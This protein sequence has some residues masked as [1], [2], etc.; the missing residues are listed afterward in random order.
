VKPK[1]FSHANQQL[2]FPHIMDNPEH[3]HHYW[4]SRHMVSPL[5]GDFFETVTR[6]LTGAKIIAN[7]NGETARFGAADLI[8]DKVIY[9]SKA[10]T[11]LRSDFTFGSKQLKDYHMF[12][13]NGYEMKYY[14]WEYLKPKDLKMTTFRTED[15]LFQYLADNVRSLIV[16][17]HKQ[18][19]EMLPPDQLEGIWFEERDYVRLYKKKVRNEIVLKGEGQTKLNG[20]TLEYEIYGASNSKN[21]DRRQHRQKPR[22]DRRVELSHQVA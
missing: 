18:L 14:L 6:E 7:D 11:I 13:E 20:F 17:T 21:L 1:W 22:R 12:D 9:E 16:L 5:V 10:T 3:E 4:I 2:M 19:W 15:K 8:K